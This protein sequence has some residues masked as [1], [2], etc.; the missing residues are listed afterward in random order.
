MNYNINPSKK[1]HTIQDAIKLSKK[2]LPK[3][4]DNLTPKKLGFEINE[5]ELTWKGICDDCQN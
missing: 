3:G 4:I 1:I 5:I 2:R